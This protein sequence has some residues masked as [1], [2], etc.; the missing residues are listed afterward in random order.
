MPIAGTPA[1]AYL[2]FRGITGYFDDLSYH[3]RCPWGPK[4]HTRFL[5]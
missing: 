5:P 3:P 2:R 4:P 1:E